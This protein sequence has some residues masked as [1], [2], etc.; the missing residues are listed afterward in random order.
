M[1]I[2]RERILYNIIVG[3]FQFTLYLPVLFLHNKNK[4]TL[5]FKTQPIK[6]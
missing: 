6:K 1:K 3:L 2:Y 5:L 4:L